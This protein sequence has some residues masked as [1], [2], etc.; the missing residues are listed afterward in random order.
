M[1]VSRQTAYLVSSAILVCSLS[2]TD[3][4]FLSEALKC[5]TNSAVIG[6]SNKVNFRKQQL[7]LYH[8]QFHL[9]QP[10]AHFP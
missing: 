6:I 1:K 9:E 5:L 2:R 7:R 3:F 8:Y 4:S 10:H